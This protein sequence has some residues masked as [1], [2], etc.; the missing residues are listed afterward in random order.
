MLT[1]LPLPPSRGESPTV[2]LGSHPFGPEAT[3]RSVSQETRAAEV[4][5][6][7][8]SPK[9]IL[10][11]KD[12]AQVMAERRRLEEAQPAKVIPATIM[13]PPDS[14]YTGGVFFLNINFPSDYPFKP[15][16]VHFTTKIYH[17]NIAQVYLKDR[18]KHDATARDWVA[19]YA[20]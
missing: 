16:K 7:V 3:P 14:P 17:C 18:A 8:K 20:T 15:P 2:V 6:R 1:P 19:K 10:R 11:C 9:R 4:K 5:P 13:G 12:F